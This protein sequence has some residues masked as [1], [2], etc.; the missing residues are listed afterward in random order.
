MERLAIEYAACIDGMEV[1]KAAFLSMLDTH[2]IEMI[3]PELSAG[4]AVHICLHALRLA[5]VALNPTDLM[6][7][8]ILSSPPTSEVPQ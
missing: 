6:Q 5:V 7:Q 2:T 4:E 8:A 3:P 1:M